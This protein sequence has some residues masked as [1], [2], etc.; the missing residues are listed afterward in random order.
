M[1][2]TTPSR[3]SILVV[4]FVELIVRLIDIAL[5]VELLQLVDCS[6]NIRLTYLVYREKQFVC[7]L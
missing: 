1:A 3:I 5:L 7:F 4:I 6:I 2:F